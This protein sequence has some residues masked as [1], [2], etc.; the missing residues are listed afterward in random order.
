MR[1]FEFSRTL[2]E[3]SMKPT[4]L[5]KMAE[6]YNGVVGL[7]FEMIVPDV[8]VDDGGGDEPDYEQDTSTDSIDEVIQFFDTYDANSSLT[9]RTLR[10]Q[11]T[12]EY[13]D[14]AREKAGDDWDT[15]QGDYIRDFIANNNYYDKE[16]AIEEATDEI[17]E[18]NPNLDPDSIEFQ[19]L[20]KAR[21]QEMFDEFVEDAIERRTR[22]GREIADDAYNDYI[23][24]E[25]DNHSESDFLRDTYPY[26]SD[27][28]NNFGVN[29]PYTT[30]SGG[31]QSIREVAL[32]FMKGIGATKIACSDEYHGAY[33]KYVGGNWDYIGN[34][35]PNDCYTVEPDGSLD[36]DSSEDGGLEFVSP[37][38]PVSEMTEQIKKVTDWAQSYGCYTNSSTGL[39]MNVSIEGYT[40][41]D[42]DYVKLALLLGDQYVLKQFERQSNTYA[43]SAMTKIAEILAAN[44]DKATQVLDKMKNHLNKVASE[45]IHGTETDKYTSINTKSN[46]IEFRGPGEDY[47]NMPTEKLINTM[48]RFVVSLAAAT[49]EN[50]YKKEY[51]TKLYK[52]LNPKG[53]QDPYGDMMKEFAEY[54]ANIGGASAET[55]KQIR[56]ISTAYLKQANIRKQKGSSQMYWWRVTE[57]KRNRSIEVAARNEQYARAKAEEQWGL[58]EQGL[59]QFNSTVELLR[60]YKPTDE[61]QNEPEWIVYPAGNVEAGKRI[62]GQGP[63]TAA[64]NA[65][66]RFPAIGAIPLQDVR[67]QLV[68]TPENIRLATVAGI[69]VAQY[70]PEKP[71]QQGTHTFVVVNDTGAELGK[72]TASGPKGSREAL[73]GFQNFLRGIGRDS[74]IGFDYKEVLVP[75]QPSP[76][77]QALA[78]DRL[79]LTPWVIVNNET[80]R[81]ITGFLASSREQAEMRLRL[82]LD[83]NPQVS[84]SSVS[85]EPEDRSETSAPT[86]QQVEWEV[87]HR[88]TNRPAYTLTASNVNDAWRLAQAWA[89]RAEQSI[90]NFDRQNYSVRRTAQ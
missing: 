71:T 87:Y 57:P 50:A 19:D 40:K 18:A 53:Q 90:P 59:N 44:P 43:K 9:L 10:D 23:D 15:V 55:V 42:L 79:V 30:S 37:P 51:A 66:M 22:Q 5:S 72:F 62:R 61:D 67:I 33:Y 60:P 83:N 74:T 80:N 34:T 35:K 68:Q 20:V 16:D 89:D 46:Y 84:P 21:E 77:A 24:S 4:V 28:E 88:Q 39:H 63:Q 76:Q 29:W 25:V 48:N 49:D 11:L 36:P 85:V 7:E 47:L 6:K 27:I 31:N 69:N 82:W 26:M 52:L 78:T 81:A 32:N 1:E 14:W 65:R 75:R 13:D 12:S 73:I 3:I 8:S 54:S 58:P 17:K 56:K 86:E 38:F 64:R 70:A 41:L 2:L 45:V